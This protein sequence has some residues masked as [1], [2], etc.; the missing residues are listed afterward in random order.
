MGMRGN[1]GGRGGCRAEGNKGW[2]KWDNCN[3]IMNKIYF[4]K[5]KEY[6]DLTCQSNLSAI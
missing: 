3:S 2:G 4:L 6:K 1:A 5:K